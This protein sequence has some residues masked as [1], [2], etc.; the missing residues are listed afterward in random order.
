MVKDSVWYPRRVKE[1]HDSESEG[2]ILVWQGD[3]AKMQV[4]ESVAWTSNGLL[5]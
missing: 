5:F 4:Q 2:A 1:G 3:R